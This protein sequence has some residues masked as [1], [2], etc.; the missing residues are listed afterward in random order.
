M[1]LVK[2]INR[3]KKTAPA[4][5]VLALLTSCQNT[6]ID[7][8]YKFRCKDL[9][10]CLILM[11]DGG[12]SSQIYQ[13]IWG[14]MLMDAGYPVKYDY[15]FY[16]DDGKDM[17]G[18]FD[19]SYVLDKLCYLDR[20]VVAPRYQAKY[21]RKHYLNPL[22]QSPNPSMVMNLHHS[23]TIP[24]YLGNYYT[25][26]DDEYLDCLKKYVK[27]RPIEEILDQNSYNLYNKIITCESVGVHI[28]RGDM[29]QSTSQWTTPT[30]NYFVQTIQSEEFKG[31]EFF[32]FSDEL[33]WVEENL[34]PLLPNEKITLMKQNTS[35]KGYVDLYLLSR[36]KHQIAS[37]GSFGVLGFALNPNP[38]KILMF[39]LGSRDSAGARLKSETVIYFDLDG[40][41][42]C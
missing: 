24:Q 19:R 21:Y 13:Y 33:D 22:N 20:V 8:I 25:C 34:L 40:N 26:N 30:I 12:I 5:S 6:I 39:P 7:H 3:V 31:K 38:D 16:D 17:N 2:I 37:Q 9:D 23:W 36:C 32:L 42:L 27:F 18:Q 11:C 41:R 15:T 4:T 10:P 28:R 35:E 14:Q 29:V 1:Y